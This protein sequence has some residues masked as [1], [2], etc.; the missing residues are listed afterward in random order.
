[1]VKI[2]NNIVTTGFSGK[3]GDLIVFRCVGNKTIVATAPHKSAHGLTDPQIL[4]QRK[5]QDAIFYGKSILSDPELKSQY[6]AKAKE[7]ESAYNVAVADFL[8]APDIKEVDFSKYTGAVGSQISVRA[9]DDFKV[10]EVQVEIL[11]GDGTLVERGA[12][13]QTDNQAEWIFVATVANSSIY[14]DK[15]VVKATD[16]PGNLTEKETVLND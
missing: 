9:I 16:M 12:A 4:Q 8:N 1:M 2:K 14:G 3:L 5:F 6:G 15:I 7:G 13:V 11:D 10:T